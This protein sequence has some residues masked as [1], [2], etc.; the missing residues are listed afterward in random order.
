VCSEGQDIGCRVGLN[1]PNLNFNCV[2]HYLH[3]LEKILYLSFRFFNS[4][5]GIILQI[6]FCYVVLT[7]YLLL[8]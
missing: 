8:F 2:S 6:N 4:K 5:M 1:S 3:V 7:M